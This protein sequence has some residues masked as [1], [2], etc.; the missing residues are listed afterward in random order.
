[1]KISCVEGGFR[2]R[3]Y[4]SRDVDVGDFIVPTLCVGMNPASL[5][6]ALV[7]DAEQGCIPTQSV[8]TMRAFLILILMVFV[9]HTPRGEDDHIISIRKAQKHEERSYWQNISR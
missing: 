6:G 4:N 3:P 1:M 9:V 7:N 8:G 2:T 5:C